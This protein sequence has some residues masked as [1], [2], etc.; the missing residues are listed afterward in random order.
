MKLSIALIPVAIVFVACATTRSQPKPTNTITLEAVSTALSRAESISFF[1]RSQERRTY[2]G[3]IAKTAPAFAELQRILQ[4]GASVHREVDLT[5]T[6]EFSFMLPATLWLC[7]YD[8][9]TQLMHVQAIDGV[10]RQRNLTLKL[11]ES[12]SEIWNEARPVLPRSFAAK[13]KVVSQAQWA[14]LPLNLD[15]LVRESSH[16]FTG[17]PIDI[18]RNDSMV[19]IIEEHPNWQVIVFEVFVDEYFKDTTRLRLPVHKQYQ[20]GGYLAG[21]FVREYDPLMVIGRRYFFFSKP[22]NGEFSW[23]PKGRARDAYLDEL[24]AAHPLSRTPI[25]DGYTALA[26]PALLPYYTFLDGKI[27]L[28]N[29]P[30]RDLEKDIRAAIKRT[31]RKK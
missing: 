31:E 9:L 12:I 1:Q 14:P 10:D 15:E 27:T 17:V 30:E 20:G 22:P 3:K 16:I 21:G 8:A 26:N 28:V 29:R 6:H 24:I 5:S 11:S 25:I 2:V 13:P 19:D 23:T 18:F 4:Q 7:R